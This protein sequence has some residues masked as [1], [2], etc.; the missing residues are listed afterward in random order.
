MGFS[1]PHMR[2]YDVEQWSAELGQ[3]YKTYAEKAM[4]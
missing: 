2:L 1:M 4:R 3:K